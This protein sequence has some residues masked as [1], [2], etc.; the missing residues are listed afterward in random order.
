MGKS[1]LRESVMTQSDVLRLRPSSG[2]PRSKP[3]LPQLG[4]A[5]LDLRGRSL[6]GQEGAG[7]RRALRAVRVRVHQGGDRQAARATALVVAASSPEHPRWA[8]ERP[9]ALSTEH[10]R[11]AVER[12][13]APGTWQDASSYRIFDLYCISWLY[14]LVFVVDVV[15]V[16]VVIVVVL[17]V[18][19]VGVVVAVA[20]VVVEVVVVSSSCEPLRN[21]SRMRCCPR[22]RS[23][24]RGR[25]VVVVVVVVVADVLIADRF[26]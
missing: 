17:L 14:V 15:L 18:F 22:G 5:P 11:S 24:S 7:V 10:P 13:R 8:V 19:V 1:V 2:S 9:R 21:S 23:C 6:P 16:V 26:G 20:V 25:S 3:D 4:Q 12:P